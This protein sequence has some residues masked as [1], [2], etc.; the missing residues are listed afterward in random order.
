[1]LRRFL[2]GIR[3]LGQQLSIVNHKYM[4]A[5]TGQAPFRLARFLKLF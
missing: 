4:I 3:V 2:V 5:Q 1:V